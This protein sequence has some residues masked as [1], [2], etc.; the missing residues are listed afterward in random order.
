[1]GDVPRS[2][3]PGVTGDFLSILNFNDFRCGWKTRGHSA[4]QNKGVDTALLLDPPGNVG[5]KST[6]RSKQ[7]LGHFCCT[8][9]PENL[10]L[11]NGAVSLVPACQNQ[12]GIIHTM[13]VVQMAQKKMGGSNRPDTRFQQPLTG[14]RSVVE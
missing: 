2:D 10:Q 8:G 4:S 6:V 9:R 14:T 3:L 13:V 12:A 5:P 1:M 11:R 7:C